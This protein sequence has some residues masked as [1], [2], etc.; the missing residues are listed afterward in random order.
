MLYSVFLMFRLFPLVALILPVL[1]ILE[2]PK[3]HVPNLDGNP[4]GMTPFFVVLL[5]IPLP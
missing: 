5:Q 1:P 3:V 2:V 4:Y